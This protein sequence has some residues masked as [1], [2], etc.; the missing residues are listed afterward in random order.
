MNSK[1][2][3]RY[4]YYSHYPEN[5]VCIIMG[6]SGNT[7]VLIVDDNPLFIMGLTSLLESYN[8]F[9]IVG[10]AEN[11]S[12][13]LRLAEKENPR[14]VIMEVTLGKE[15]GMELIQKLKNIN[16]E[17]VILIM[18][19][20]DERYYS[21]RIL[22]MGARG[23]V[24]KTS[25]SN[26]VMDAV[27]TVLNGRVY[28]S[29]SEKDR[30]FQAM[31]DDSARGAKNWTISIEKLSNRELQV[32]LLIGKG[33]GTIEIASRL[34]LSTKTIDTHKEHIK[35]KLHCS[36]AQELRYLAIEWSNISGSS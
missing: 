4:L 13:A 17:I 35:Q 6:R 30:I 34:S 2:D 14:L 32:F 12:S 16:Q 31:A 20:N 19:M 1:Q 11:I 18:S 29:E 33:Y 15:N 10:T 36:S 23:Y 9:S 27:F 7:R 26:I 24:M 25:P 5:M 21:E 28:L 22:R 8:K 3:I